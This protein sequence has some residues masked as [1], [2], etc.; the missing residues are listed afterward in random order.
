MAML[1]MTVVARAASTTGGTMVASG[2][3]SAR[4]VIPARREIEEQLDERDALMVT[5]PCADD[6]GIGKSQHRESFQHML[7]LERHDREAD[8][9]EEH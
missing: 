7:V 9:G 5:G 3:R 1:M 4:A 6:A 2:I 8:G